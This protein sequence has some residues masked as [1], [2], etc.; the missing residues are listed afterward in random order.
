MNRTLCGMGLAL[1]ALL[2]GC[3][4]TDSE[5]ASTDSPGTSLNSGNSSNAPSP[6]DETG[7]YSSEFGFDA[8]LPA[9]WIL[10]DANQIRNNP[11]LF[12]NAFEGEAS[13][14]IDPGLAA[15]LK[16]SI[17]AGKVEYYFRDGETHLDF[18][19]NIN[20]QKSVGRLPSSE[21]DVRQI[22]DQ[23]GGQLGQAFGRPVR[24]ME[25]G[26]RDT[27]TAQGFYIEADGAIPGSVMTQYQ[28]Q[29]DRSILLIVT[30]T[31]HPDTLASVRDELTGF[32]RSVSF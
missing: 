17:E 6:P 32:I 22:C 20:A 9:G 18:A 29:L 21:D 3:P 2:L 25:C 14:G 10:L 13:S 28:L 5:D 11:D 16:S 27:G 30:A 15:Q 31:S 8:T 12:A 24:V 19:D 23:V 26:L 1:L 4:A 7:R